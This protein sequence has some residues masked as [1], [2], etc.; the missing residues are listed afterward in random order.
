MRLPL[1]EELSERADVVAA[2][3]VRLYVKYNIRHFRLHFFIISIPM[4]IL[5]IQEAT[6]VPESRQ[7]HHTANR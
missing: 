3:Q 4:S 2:L 6:F 7:S 5:L 1:D